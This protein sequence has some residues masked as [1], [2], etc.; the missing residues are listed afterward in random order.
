MKTALIFGRACGVWEEVA[1]AQR[2][3]PYDYTLAVGSA[4][5]DYPGGFAHWV[6]FHT[7]LLPY[8]AECRSKLG[9]T[10][11]REYWSAKHHQS[12]ALPR[13]S[14]NV[15]FPINYIHCDGGSS[16]LIAVM[17]ALDALKVDRVVLAGIPMDPERAQYDVISQPW[18]EALKHRQAWES[19]LNKLQGRVRSMSGWTQQFLGGAPPTIDWLTYADAVAA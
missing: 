14:K 18:K 15:V 10:P 1:E 7:L 19:H 2:W 3:H 11:A 5:V 6:S 17:V 9:R 12:P 13:R 16:G 4:G 8:W